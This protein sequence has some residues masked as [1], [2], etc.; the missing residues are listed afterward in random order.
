MSKIISVHSFRGGTGKSH[1][2]ANLAA[3]LAVQGRR[4][5]VVDTDLPSPGSV[6]LT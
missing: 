6:L 2:T 5:A 3:Q 1:L 4:V